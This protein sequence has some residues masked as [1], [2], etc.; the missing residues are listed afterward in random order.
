M[1]GEEGIEQ[2]GEE[3]APKLRQEQI[4]HVPGTERRPVATIVEEGYG[5]GR[6]VGPL[7]ECSV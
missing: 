2:A 7:R 4:W 5:V 1:Q 6:Q 3:Y